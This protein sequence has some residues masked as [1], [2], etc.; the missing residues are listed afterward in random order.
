MIRIE[1]R[2]PIVMRLLVCAGI[3]VLLLGSVVMA[4]GELLLLPRFQML[5]SQTKLSVCLLPFLVAF[6]IYV[7]LQVIRARHT[8]TTTYV[9]TEGGIS[10]RASG[11]RAK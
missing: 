3:P 8:L 7:L 5:D 9:L 1:L 11:G 10:I 2:F 4:W 6:F